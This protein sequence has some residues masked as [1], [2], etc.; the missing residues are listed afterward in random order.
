MS[1]WRRSSRPSEYPRY[2]ADRNAGKGRFALYGGNATSGDLKTMYDGMRPEKIGYVPM[3][4]Q[5]SVVLSVAGDNSD[6][7]GGRFYEGAIALGAANGETIDA[8]QAAIVDAGYG[9]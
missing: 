1:G 5:G 4:K 6:R 8:L 3:Q 7:D 9:R 2:T